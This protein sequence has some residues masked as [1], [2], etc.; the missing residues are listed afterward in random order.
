M[1]RLGFQKMQDVQIRHEIKS[2][3]RY[4]GGKSKAIKQIL[5]R[6]PK[7][8]EYREP[9]LGGGSVFASIKQ[10]VSKDIPFW[11]NDLN[12]DV[13]C[14]WFHVK[15]NGVKLV[16]EVQRIKEKY[17]DGRVLFSYFRNEE[18]EWTDFE[19]AVRFFVLNRIT[20]SGTVDA[21]GYSKAAFRSRFTQSS[22]DRL[23]KLSNLMTNV[24][25]TPN[26]YQDIVLAK[27]EEV[28]LFLDPPYFST[29][30]SRLYGK[31]GSLHTAFD[32]ERFAKVMKK[33]K[34]KWLITYDDCP[35][36]RDS[37]NF[38]HIEEWSLQYGMNNYQQDSA[39]RGRELFIS[40]YT[41]ELPADKYYQKTLV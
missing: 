24:K 9:F 21:G 15:E 5:P 37:F 31:N 33:C 30:E 25:V 13:Y 7:F 20:F 23:G 32:H 10:R 40:N 2:P 41:Y 4:P 28:F 22:I 18:T 34:H 17:T 39:K 29:T 14:F 6:I 36:V 35:Q 1:I 3:L 8:K 19:R 12:Y 16:N 26:D 11:I 38:A 27:G